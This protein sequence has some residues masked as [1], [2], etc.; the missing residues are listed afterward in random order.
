[1]CRALQLPGNPPV[2]YCTKIKGT[3]IKIPDPPV[4]SHDGI[5]CTGESYKQVVKFAFFQ[6]TPPRHG[7]SQLGSPHTKEERLYA[8]CGEP[9]LSPMNFIL[10]RIA[11]TGFEIAWNLPFPSIPRT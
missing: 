1:M 6:A 4:C 11:S 10:N 8:G 9:A 2:C 7:G 3:P 5:V